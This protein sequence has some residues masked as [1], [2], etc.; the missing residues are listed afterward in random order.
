MCLVASMMLDKEMV[1]Q[2]VQIIDREAF[3]QADHQIIYDVLVKLYEQKRQQEQEI[4]ERRRCWIEAAPL[5][6]YLSRPRDAEPPQ[7]E[8]ARD[9][10][11]DEQHRE[12]DRDESPQPACADPNPPMNGQMKDTRYDST[13]CY[14]GIAR[15][16]VEAHGLEPGNRVLLRGP[17]SYTMFAAWLG[18]LKAGGLAVATMPLLRQ[19]AALLAEL[20]AQSRERGVAGDA[21]AVGQRRGLAGAGAAAEVAQVGARLRQVELARRGDLGVEGDLARLERRGEGALTGAAGVEPVAELA[22]LAACQPGHLARVAGGL[23]RD[24]RRR[25][26]GDRAGPAPRRNPRR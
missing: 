22:L 21:Q 7:R 12:H 11:R 18:I 15:L 20:E 23:L 25:L 4:I 17:N 6:S 5:D 26:G 10:P 14:D 19:V 9:H 16:L 3:Y 2:A 1:G 24:L 8:D 13:Y